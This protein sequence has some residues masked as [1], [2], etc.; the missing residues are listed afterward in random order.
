MLTSALEQARS[1]GR[2]EGKTEGKA[3]AVLA[4]LAAR[5]VAV[6][7]TSRAAIVAMRDVP[8]LDR[9]LRLAATCA[10]VAELFR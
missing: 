2:N 3:E 10:D 4:V 5:G 6:D 7:D 9:W 1:A 8:V